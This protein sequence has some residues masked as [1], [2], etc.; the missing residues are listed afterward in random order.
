MRAYVRVYVRV[1]EERADCAFH[2]GA[3]FGIPGVILALVEQVGPFYE[4]ASLLSSHV[5]PTAIG[6]CQKLGR[7][8]GFGVYEP[9]QTTRNKSSLAKQPFG[10]VYSQSRTGVFL[11]ISYLA[12][13]MNVRPC[14]K[15]VTCVFSG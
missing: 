10:K 9:P 13:C 5:L 2:G 4:F 6:S 15:R 14:M 7:A 12:A 8:A 11:G 1:C 3:D